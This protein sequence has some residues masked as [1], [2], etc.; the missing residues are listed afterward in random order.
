PRNLI[1]I[2]MLIVFWLILFLNADFLE[3]VNFI[4][5]FQKYVELKSKGD[6]ESASPVISILFPVIRAVTF[7]LILSQ[8]L[9]LKIKQRT[10]FLISLGV[11]A[12][13]ATLILGTSRFSV[14]YSTL[15]LVLI[16]AYV[17]PLYQK[18]ITSIT[19]IMLFGVLIVSSIT[20]F[21]R[22]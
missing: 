2:S 1:T 16:L 14:V 19:F 10:K 5:D 18:K 13:N 20:K 3:R 17:F 11:I 6:L 21:S 4:W 12:L 15:P 7:L 8:I 9:T 22:G